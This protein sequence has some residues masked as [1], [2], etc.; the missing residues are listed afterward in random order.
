MQNYERFPRLSRSVEYIARNAGLSMQAWGEFTDALNEVC[1]PSD[2]EGAAVK[3][4]RNLECKCDSYY[5][6]TCDRCKF[7]SSI[8]AAPAQ[9]PK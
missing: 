4:I 2:T 5:G 9:E 1:A 8:P 3:F 6:R 7:L